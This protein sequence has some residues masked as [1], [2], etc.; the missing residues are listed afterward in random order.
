MH[1]GSYLASLHVGYHSEIQC[2]TVNLWLLTVLV[3][4]PYHFGTQN[5]GI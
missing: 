5:N 4:A 1:K 2:Y 3:G